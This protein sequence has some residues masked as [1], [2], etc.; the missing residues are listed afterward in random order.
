V[1]SALRYRYR[2]IGTAVS[3]SRYRHC[4]VEGLAGDRWAL[5]SSKEA[6]A[7]AALTSLA[8]HE[9]FLPIG[10][11][12][13]L[14]FRLPQRQVITVTTNVPGPRQPLYLAGR[15]LLEIFPYVPIATT[16]RFGVSIF[17][18]CD[19]ITFGVTGDYDTAPDLDLLAG[20][21]ER[22]VAE[23][24]AAAHRRDGSRPADPG[25]VARS[26]R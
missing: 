11:G 24:A 12:I 1:V 10:L 23:L 13:R 6:A 25:R 19:R 20:G 21:I 17:T 18:Y 16:L 3:A 5:T 22:G 2:G 7:G 8:R 4:G 26:G 9:P 14:A 15:R